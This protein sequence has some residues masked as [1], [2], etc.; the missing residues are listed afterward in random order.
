MDMHFENE[1]AYVAMELTKAW[2]AAKNEKYDNYINE[3]D[4]EI[5]ACHNLNSTLDYLKRARETVL[6]SQGS[7]QKIKSEY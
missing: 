3:E 4:N 5:I 2:I 6:I 1:Q 7:R